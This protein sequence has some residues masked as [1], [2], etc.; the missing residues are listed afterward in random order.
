[1]KSANT[2]R[3]CNCG[4]STTCT[5]YDGDRQIPDVEIEGHAVI[6]GDTLRDWEISATGLDKNRQW[7]IVQKNYDLIEQ[8]VKEFFE[9]G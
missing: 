8:R 3:R 7:I 9:V 5:M 1:M 2:S 4:F 6:D